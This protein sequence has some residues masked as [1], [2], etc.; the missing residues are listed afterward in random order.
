MC[1]S[2]T[3]G[4]G[5]VA[6]VATY[7]QSYHNG[8]K[9]LNKTYFLLRDLYKFQETLNT[10][11][12]GPSVGILILSTLRF[13]CWAP[14]TGQT[15]NGFVVAREACIHSPKIFTGT[16]KISFRRPSYY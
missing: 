8:I 7:Q 12:Q 11:I 10:K 5:I 14:R 15:T 13:M 1:F 9:E 2:E 6:L 3:S 16:L 4:L